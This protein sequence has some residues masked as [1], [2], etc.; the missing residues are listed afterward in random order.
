MGPGITGFSAGVAIGIA[1]SK[2]EDFVPL[3]RSPG[4]STAKIAENAVD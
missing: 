2:S 1:A 4:W 3:R